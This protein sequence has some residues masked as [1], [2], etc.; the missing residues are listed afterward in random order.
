MTITPNLININHE[1][2]HII[3]LII[4]H[5]IQVEER[6]RQT[7]EELNTSTGLLKYLREVT[8]AREREIHDIRQCL[9]ICQ[10]ERNRLQNERNHLVNANRDQASQLQDQQEKAIGILHAYLT[11]L[12]ARWYDSNILGKRVKLR[13]ILLHLAHGDEAAFKALLGNNVNCPANIWVN[14]GAVAYMV[15]GADNGIANPVTNIW[16]NYAIEGNREIWLIRL[17]WSLL[18]TLLTTMLLVVQLEVVLQLLV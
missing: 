12:A 6:A 13:N 2:K 9:I 10:N 8:N 11:G 1:I 7:R 5:S 4:A 14:P 17:V 3:G 18:M 16:P 15:D